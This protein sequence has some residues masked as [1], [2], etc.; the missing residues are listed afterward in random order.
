[1]EFYGFC[2]NW[3]LQTS[4]VPVNFDAH[5]CSSDPVAAIPDGHL[6]LAKPIRFNDGKVDLQGRLWA[7]TMAL[8]PT[9]NPNAGRFYCLRRG[10]SLKGDATRASY[11]L[12]EKISPVGISNGMDWYGQHMYYID[13]LKPVWRSL[14]LKF[15]RKIGRASALCTCQVLWGKSA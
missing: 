12:V 4:V 13:S 5:G 7:G 2:V 15:D 11:D 6:D 14:R 10:A 3:M 9:A 8:D 1:M